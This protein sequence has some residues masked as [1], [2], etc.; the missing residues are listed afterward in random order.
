MWTQRA[1]SQI[2][3]LRTVVCFG[4]IFCSFCVLYFSHGVESVDHNLVVGLGVYGSPSLEA[5]SSSIG[6]LL[7]PRGK[8]PTIEDNGLSSLLNG[9]TV[10]TRCG[11]CADFVKLETMPL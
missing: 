11:L 8:I 4:W 7:H 1:A 3:F 5:E 10:H 6:P 9:V 2:L